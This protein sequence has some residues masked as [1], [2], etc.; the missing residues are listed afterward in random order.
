M[1]I[2]L[3]LA[4]LAPLLAKI[5]QMATSRQREYLADAS[6]AQM[7]RYPEGLASALEK[8]AG[9]PGELEAANRGTQHLYIVNPLRARRESGGSLFS[10]HPEVVE[11]VR[12][13]RAMA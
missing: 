6:A 11:R 5:I 12:R 13:L 8:I 9:S 10:T 4:I 1:L 3:V 7:T 2:A